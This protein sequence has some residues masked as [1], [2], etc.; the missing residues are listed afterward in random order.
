MNAELIMLIGGVAA[1]LLT[2]YW[3]RSRDL[4]EKYALVWL[5]VAFVGL[6]CGLFPGL[7]KRFAEQAHLSY[8]TA[9][10]LFAFAAF[11]L[12]SFSVSVSLSRQYRRNMRLTQELAILEERV[13][14]LE[15]ARPQ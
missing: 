2:I 15:S 11:Y 3:V 6:L 10:M 5:A 4:R 13:R 14:Q 12:F 1:F 8:A 9:V 7:I